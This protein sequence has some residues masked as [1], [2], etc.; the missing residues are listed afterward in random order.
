MTQE[1]KPSWAGMDVL[2]YWQ[3]TIDW[4]KF[5]QGGVSGEMWAKFKELVQLCQAY[6][7]WEKATHEARRERPSRPLHGESAYMRRKHQAE[8]KRRAEVPE[9]HIN[10]AGFL[11]ASKI[12]EMSYLIGPSDKGSADG[13][14]W[15]ALRLTAAYR[16][17][18]ENE[19]R[20]NALAFKSFNA[21]DELQGE[22]PQIAVRWLKVAGYL[23]SDLDS[24]D[25]ENSGTP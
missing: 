19:G 8:W 11:A 12:A 10:R 7:H 2:Q 20:Y 14:M 18:R 5:D 16:P 4:T 15:I 24:L 9:G 13:T 25:H 23:S 22:P 17:L 21:N 3:P 6:Q 1:S